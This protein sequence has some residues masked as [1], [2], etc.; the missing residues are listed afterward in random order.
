[1]STCLKFFYSPWVSTTNWWAEGKYW[2]TIW[3]P[4]RNDQISCPWCMCAPWKLKGKVIFKEE[5]KK[6][7]DEKLILKSICFS[8]K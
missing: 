3:R 5:I 7:I 2:S 4:I 8:N 6:E 1:M